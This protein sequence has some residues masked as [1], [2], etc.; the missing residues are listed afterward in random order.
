MMGLVSMSLGIVSGVSAGASFCLSFGCCILTCIRAI[1]TFLAQS[2]SG[3]E[4][5]VVALLV[6][7]LGHC[8]WS[9]KA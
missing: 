2:A 6:L 1:L 4:V 5:G 8:G 7:M 9:F 3:C